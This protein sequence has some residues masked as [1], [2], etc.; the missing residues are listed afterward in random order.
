MAAVL[1]RVLD[2]DCSGDE[3]YRPDSAA[4]KRL[5]WPVMGVLLMAWLV[6]SFW[7]GGQ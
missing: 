3:C 1:S 2:R 4:M 6:L 7:I 5:L